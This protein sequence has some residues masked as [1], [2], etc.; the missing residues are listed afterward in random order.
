MRADAAVLMKLWVDLKSKR[1]V[2]RVLYL[3]IELHNPARSQ[4]DD[5][6]RVEGYSG[7]FIYGHRRD[8]VIVIKEFNGEQLFAHLLVP[9]REEVVIVEPHAILKVLGFLGWRQS[10]H[11]D[12]SCYRH[13]GCYEARGSWGRRHRC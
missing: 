8:H 2:R 1:A 6:V 9:L 10:L 5:S 4:L 3:N 7:V 13:Q 11:G 12:R